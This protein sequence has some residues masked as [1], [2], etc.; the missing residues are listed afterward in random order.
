MGTVNAWAYMYSSEQR[1]ASKRHEN[2]DTRPTM[3]VGLLYVRVCLYGCV[4]LCIC[5]RMYKCDCVCVH[6]GWFPGSNSPKRIRPFYKG[7]N[8]YTK[9]D[10]N[11]WN[12]QKSN[13]PICYTSF[14]LPNGLHP[15][16]P[17]FWFLRLIEPGFYTRPYVLTVL[18]LQAPPLNNSFCIFSL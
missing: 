10:Q 1:A 11:Q 17:V 9:Y 6:K 2:K 14:H 3:Y 16:L 18:S 5:V 7:L 15:L 12:P 4:I 13:P 8:M